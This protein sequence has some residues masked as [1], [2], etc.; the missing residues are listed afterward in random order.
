MLAEE[1]LDAGAARQA[2]AEKGERAEVEDVVVLDLRRQELGVEHPAAVG[3]ERTDQAADRAADHDVERDLL[4]LE[5]AQHA[6]VGE[7]ARPAAAERQA[8]P[9]RDVAHRHRRQHRRRS[10]PASDRQRDRGEQRGA[11]V[12]H[13]SSSPR[14]TVS[15]R[16][17]SST[18]SPIARTRT[19]PPRREAW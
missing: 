7:A 15:A 11:G 9:R 6:D 10:G 18:R 12:L 8:D 17:A 1:A 19:T 14:S 3:V 16:P 13:A 4:L 2:A 5:D